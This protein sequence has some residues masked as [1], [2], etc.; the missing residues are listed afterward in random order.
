MSE[1]LPAV[2]ADGDRNR[3]DTGP[4]GTDVDSRDMYFSPTLQQRV[5]LVEHLIEFGRQIIVLSG[6]VD[7]GKT[8]LLNHFAT[9]QRSSWYS[10]LAHAGPALT[11]TALLTLLA[12]E[13]EADAAAPEQGLRERVQQRIATL[14]RAGKVVVLLVDDAEQLLPEVSALIVELAHADDQFAEL[15]VLLAADL[16]QSALLEAL[17]RVHPQHGLVHVVEIPKLADPQVRALLEQRMRSAGLEAD[18]C[19][20]AD[21][22]ARIAASAD[23]LIG[24]VVTLARQHV[25]GIAAPARATPS[26]RQRATGRA[27]GRAVP[28]TRAHVNLAFG[29]LAAAALAG[30]AWW[31]SRNPLDTSTQ[32]ETVALTPPAAPENV[33]GEAPPPVPTQAERAESPSPIEPSPPPPVEIAPTPSVADAATIPAP[34]AGDGRL[35]AAIAP[36]PATRVSGAGETVPA[37][38]VEL[39]PAPPESGIQSL[40][41]RPDLPT[42]SSPQAK[43]PAV[44][45]EA[46]REPVTAHATTTA[47]PAAPASRAAAPMAGPAPTPDAAPRPAAPTP[48]RP[49]PSV[50]PPAQ[51]AAA[52]NLSAPLL[53]RQPDGAH[54]LQLF[55]VRERAAAERYR[56]ARGIA[57]QSVVL[58]GSLD[59]KPWYVVT[60]GLYPNRAAALRAMQQLPPS[61]RD[62]KPWAR[63]VGSLR[64]VLH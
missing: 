13:L 41:P 25:A 33:E 47:A 22:Y 61:L 17:Q 8:T 52:P 58:T 21:D 2:A 7:S 11:T 31:A 30:G 56:R 64:G 54:T 15:R 14:E 27:S 53:F 36:S 28:L 6:P 16:D 55:G 26:R 24:K 35:D 44:P 39:P 19:F 57:D 45:E 12:Q 62:T 40:Q 32:T 59:G 4:F 29:V 34:D 18:A 50:A 51:T 46:A 20:K 60:Y 38:A 5:D 9:A 43:S 3:I 49:A 1:D 63:S 10:V 37:P 23:G 42:V 48:A